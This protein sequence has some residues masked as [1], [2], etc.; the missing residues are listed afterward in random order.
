M[1]LLVTR[2]PAKINLTLHVLGRRPG[3]GYHELESLVV[4]T[5]SGDTLTLEPGPDLALTVSGPTAG[6]AG[7]LDDNLVIRAAR[8]LARLQPGLRHGAFH[9]VKRL[10]VAAGVGGGSSDAAAALRLLGRLNDLPPDHP[11]LV[12]AARATGA[13]VPVCLVPR[14]RM[15]SGAGEAVGPA[16]DMTPIPA[17]LVNPG[18]PVETAP[19][20]RALGLTVG[21]RHGT[22]T[23]PIIARGLSAD[24]LL[25]AITPARNDLEAPARSIAPVIDV[26]LDALR[27]AAGCRLARMS[28]SGA[29]VFG[30]F[31]HR[32][33][34]ALAAHRLARDHPAWWV[35]AAI[36]R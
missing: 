3:D 2:A 33:E 1:S 26:A 27:A 35:S 21:E 6:P 11:D 30:L 32:S 7:P 15:M 23:H 22:D 17:V 24:R 16:L 13:D 20:F 18:V 8:H 12:A 36:L 25:E 4:F 29:T 31:G 19:V 28:G 34:A 14:A 10:P 5:G 9:L